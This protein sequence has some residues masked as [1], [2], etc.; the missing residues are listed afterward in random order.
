MSPEHEAELRMALA[1]GLVSREEAAILREESRRTG[2]SPLQLLQAR[3]QVS[4]QSLALLR[5]AD[6]E[7]TL[8]PR[9][10]ADGAATLGPALTLS[11]RHKVD[12]QFPVPG[13]DRYQGLR[14][15]GQGGMGQVF[16]AYDLRLRRNVALKFVRG[17]DAELVRRLLSEARAQARVE[18]D[19]VCQVY[20]VGEVQ[21]RPYIAMQYVDGQPLSQLSDELTVEQK[22]LALRD[23][24]EGVHAA[25]KAGLIHRDLKPS[26]ILVERTDD[27]RF[28]P[29]VMDFGLAHDW[30]EKGATA[31]GSVL[32]TP[33]YMAPEQ[34]RGEVGQLDR[35]ADVYSL[36][37]TL[38]FMLTGRPPIPGDN[39]LEILSNIASLEPPHPRALNPNIPPDLEAIVLKCLEKDRSARYDSARAL[40]EDLDRFLAGEPVLARPTGLWYRL[41][42]KARKHRVV[43]G[44]AAVALLAVALALGSALYTHRQASLREELARRFTEKVETIEALARYSALSPL[45]D[46][47]EDRQNLRAHMAE[48]EAEIRD[49]GGP[50]AAGPG[51]YALARGYLAL[52]EE[53]RAHELLEAA[54]KSGFQDPRVAYSLALVMGH[55]YQEQLLEAENPRDTTPKQ[56]EER[57][58][59]LQRRYRDPALVWL[60]RSKGADVHS[61]EYVEALI[62]YYED[63]FEEA[64]LRLDALGNRFPWFYEAPQ[65]RG[66]ILRTRA[67]RR[68]S[69]GE[70]PGALEDLEAGRLA[71]QAAAAIGESVHAT[72]QSLAKLEY[73]TIVL[74]L[75]SQG[76]VMPPFTRGKEALARALKASPEERSSLLLEARLHRRLAEYQMGRG[77]DPQPA[78]QTALDAVGKALQN[79]NTSREVYL[80]QSSIF[81][82]WA[83][84][85]LN[86][87]QDP[88]EQ[89]LR[90]EQS[91]EHVAAPQRDYEFYVTLGLILSSWA[92]YEDELGLSSAEHRQR[93]I[94]AFKAATE[95]S[96]YNHE[97]WI[98]LG[99]TLLHRS[100]YPLAATVR[101]RRAQ[102]EEDLKQAWAAL[103]E[104]LRANPKHVVAN[105]Y[106]GRVLAQQARLHWCD[107]KASPLLSQAVQLLNAGLE[108]KPLHAPLRNELGKAVLAQ[109]QQAWE[110]GRPPYLLLDQAQGT[111]EE[112]IRNTPQVSYAYNNLGTVQLWRATYQ[113]AAG[114]EPRASTAAA[115]I[116][117]EQAVRRTPD[118][119]FLL[120]DQAELF[121]RLADFELERGRDPRAH[122]ERAEQV[123]Q[124]SL[125]RSPRQARAWLLLGRARA[126]LAQWKAQRGQAKEEDFEKAAQAFEKALELE[127][128]SFEARLDGGALQQAWAG[129][130]KEMG[131]APAPQLERGLAWA[132]EVLLDCPDWPRALLLR[133]KL[134]TTRAD[135]EAREEA[136]QAWRQQATDDLTRALEKNPHLKKP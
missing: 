85:H 75:Y 81:F 131:R 35:R 36:G 56:R 27:G 71:Y 31:T 26:N 22:V 12:P 108:T 134:R 28:K 68:W 45:H 29:Y 40:I 116:A 114:Q 54:W 119:A 8:V 19:R 43:V 42:K 76:E 89:L 11:E 122:L 135:L 100:A 123:L 64:L 23:A 51:N 78:I 52:G 38:Y 25:H 90:A 104:V 14:F 49:A 126:T 30:G 95:S 120:T 77:E 117:F 21:G 129:W 80:E 47:R 99:R 133:A 111:F 15:L 67:A 32:G 65:L 5:Q 46:T 13:W 84:H 34:A 86:Q 37:A 10:T 63:H 130:R 57:K 16:L 124:Q 92:Q 96:P 73:T 91:L 6:V 61:T 58:Q 20:E 4:E 93:A 136:R 112:I 102:Q 33:H 101:E 74:G 110:E 103:Q 98:N 125:K 60:R 50:L 127:P 17:D 82:W 109:A 7:P 59:E 62:A 2:Q 94:D 79:G 88:R 66:D 44:I 70:L 53:A 115:L 48:L 55:Q 1:E 113:Q 132:E 83:R 106:G 87:S 24:C 39:G 107:G 69:Q 97:A 3:G 128:E 41:R 118:D 72:H 121:S 9:A 18:H 105:L